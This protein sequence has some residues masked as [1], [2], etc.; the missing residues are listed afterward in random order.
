M[1]TGA[2]PSLDGER[3]RGLLELF[4]ERY[5]SRPTLVTSYLPVAQRHDALSDPNLVEA[6]LDQLVQHVH[7]LNSAGESLRK[8][9]PKLTDKPTAV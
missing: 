8:L 5:R 6:I 9:Q 1:T 4:D 2:W 3:R 7:P